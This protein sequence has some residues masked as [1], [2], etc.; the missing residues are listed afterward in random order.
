MKI[1][2]ILLDDSTEIKFLRGG[3]VLFIT[4]VIIALCSPIPIIMNGLVALLTIVV[5]VCCVM[6]YF[7]AIIGLILIIIHFIRANYEGIN[8]AYILIGS[9]LFVGTIGLLGG[10][11]MVKNGIG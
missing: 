7:V 1:K 2:D 11:L 6:G 5:V 8:L 9:G 10:L 3:L 4:I